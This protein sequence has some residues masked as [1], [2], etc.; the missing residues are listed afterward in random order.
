M[1]QEQLPNIL[2]VDDNPAN[3]DLLLSALEILSCRVRP[4]AQPEMALRSAIAHPPDLIL[5]DIRMPGMDGFEF[6]RS[7][8]E[9]SETANVPVIF[10][11]AME[12]QHEIQAALDLGAEG[13]LTKPIDIQKLLSLVQKFI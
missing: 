1:E 9:H 2:V 10:L 5:L 3:L 4:S 8:R 13:Y 7:L 11:S 12:E 6:F